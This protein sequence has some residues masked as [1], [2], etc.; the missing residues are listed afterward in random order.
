VRATTTSIRRLHT[1]TITLTVCRFFWPSRVEQQPVG[2]RRVHLPALVEPAHVLAARAVGQQA[3]VLPRVR[4]RRL[5][6]E[7]AVLGDPGFLEAHHLVVARR[8]E[9]LLAGLGVDRR[10]VQQQV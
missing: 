6:V 8:L 2:R 1:S 9:E 3:L 10:G 7:F 5:Q 4:I